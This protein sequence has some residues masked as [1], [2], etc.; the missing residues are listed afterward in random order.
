ME[1]KKTKTSIY[2]IDNF[3]NDF[4]LQTTLDF[5]QTICKYDNDSYFILSSSKAYS[6][7]YILNDILIDVFYM[8]SHI[9]HDF[10]NIRKVISTTL[11]KYYE[12]QD[13]TMDF[14]YLIHDNEV[15]KMYSSLFLE[16]LD[17]ISLLISNHSC[18]ISNEKQSLSIN[19]SYATE[20][21]RIFLLNF[22][23]FNQ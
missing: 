15:E 7:K 14:E 23:D 21:E 2:I 8:R 13:D 16:N 22:L 4:D 11:T 10:K 1:T 18:S 3:D 6:L 19:I 17:K 20:L 5:L 9:I 12:A